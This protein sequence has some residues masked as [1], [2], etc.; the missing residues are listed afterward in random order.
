M[1][2]HLFSLLLSHL[3]LQSYF[4]Q[5]IDLEAKKRYSTYVL[6]DVNTFLFKAIGPSID[7]VYRPEICVLNTP[8]TYSP[9]QHGATIM[10]CGVNL[11]LVWKQNKTY[12]EV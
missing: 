3:S 7:Y 6:D 5:N 10:P 12:G 2:H 9:P 11:Q 4:C 8:Y 1:L